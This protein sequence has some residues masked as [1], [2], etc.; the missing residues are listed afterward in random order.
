MDW[1]PFTKRIPDVLFF[2]HKDRVVKVFVD[3]MGDS[4]GNRQADAITVTNAPKLRSELS[5]LLRVMAFNSFA[6]PM[7]G[8]FM[9]R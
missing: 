4:K 6:S 2:A 7:R 9:V 3:I 5:R 8:D 1:S